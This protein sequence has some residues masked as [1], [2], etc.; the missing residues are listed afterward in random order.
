MWWTCDLSG[1][2][3]DH[4]PT[5][6]SPDPVSQ[7]IFRRFFKWF[8]FS[9]AV[10]SLVLQSEPHFL[11]VTVQCGSAAQSHQCANVCWA[12]Q[13]LE[14]SRTYDAEKSKGR[15]ISLGV[16][17]HHSDE[18]ITLS[19]P[20]KRQLSGTCRR[21]AWPWAF[22]TWE[23]K[24]VRERAEENNELFMNH[25]TNG[26]T[27]EE[28]HETLQ[29][30][31]NGLS[32]H[33]FKSTTVV[34]FSLYR[35]QGVWLCL[36]SSSHLCKPCLY[37]SYSVLHRYI[38]A[39]VNVTHIRRQRHTKKSQREKRAEDDELH[40]L[41]LPRQTAWAAL[42]PDVTKTHPDAEQRWRQDA[43][44]RGRDESL[45]SWAGVSGKLSLWALQ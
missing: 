36:K 12:L 21:R 40:K 37:R 11:D 38:M 14:G 44:W 13:T 25:Q 32:L 3:S 28:K 18:Q 24:K 29:T 41:E 2:L 22:S 33:G 15:A 27:E 6:T 16:F 45:S 4:L 20:D 39:T 30:T 31:F 17:F 10:F 5:S 35:S 1:W 19:D 43:E 8:L 23:K 42:N 26:K 7:N 9:I 34:V